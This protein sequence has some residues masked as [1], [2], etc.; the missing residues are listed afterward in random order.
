VVNGV[1][2]ERVRADNGSEPRPRI[3]AHAVHTGATFLVQFVRCDR[4]ALGREVLHERSAESDVHHLD[5]ATDRER[6]K[7]AQSGRREQ[8]ELGEV[9]RTV[10]GSELRVRCLAVVRGVD[11][12]AA[13]QDEA[14]HRIEHVDRGTR[15][16]Q[17]GYHDGDQSGRLERTNVRCVEPDSLDAIDNPNGS[18]D[19]HERRGDVR[20][21]S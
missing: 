21:S 5:S 14:R 3:N 10:H 2:G 6:R 11:I 13:R 20:V 12:F 15:L 16:G 18:S 8:R 9:S 4:F 7:L 17:R 19:G 1:H